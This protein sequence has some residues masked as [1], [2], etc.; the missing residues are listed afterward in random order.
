MES[1]SGF[2]ETTTMPDYFHGRR[3]TPSVYRNPPEDVL[4]K[5]KE[6]ACELST[7]YYG[8]H[9]G[10]PEPVEALTEK[11]HQENKLYKSSVM[12]FDRFPH[13]F[14]L[15]GFLNI[16]LAL[17]DVTDS[18]IF[19]GKLALSSSKFQSS[20]GIFNAIV[21]FL[22]KSREFDSAWLFE[23]L[24]DSLCMLGW[25]LK[26]LEREGKRIPTGCLQLGCIIYC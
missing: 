16:V 22:V 1:L 20:V 24:L 11:L 8:T 21:E 14:V 13:I 17:Y 3:K 26:I 19:A 2:N 7:G 9:E 6:L 4:E 15:Q 23:I 10:P 5:V 18:V 12:D 25:L